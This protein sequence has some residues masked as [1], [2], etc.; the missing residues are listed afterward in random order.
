MLVSE[1]GCWVFYRHFQVKQ[2]LIA[3][4]AKAQDW[5]QGSLLRDG[6]GGLEGGRELCSSDE[7]ND[8]E[9]SRE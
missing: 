8:S 4:W 2:A 5:N 1:P 7:Q 6:S 9:L 3:V